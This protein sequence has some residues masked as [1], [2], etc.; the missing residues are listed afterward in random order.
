MKTNRMWTKSLAFGLLMG[1]A[2]IGFAATPEAPPADI[3]QKIESAKTPANHEALAAYFANEAS[4]A[5]AQADQHA[6]MGKLYLSNRGSG[7]GLA[8]M[9]SHCEKIVKEYQ[10]M[11]TE[12]DA[13]AAAHRQA[14]KG[15]AAKP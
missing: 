14:A 12:Y 9:T 7:K 10:G 15:A 6:K 3:V 11:A 5:R 2:A 8:G 1:I 4:T 13:M